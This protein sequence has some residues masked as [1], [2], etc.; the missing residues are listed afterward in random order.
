VQAAGSDRAAQRFLD[1]GLAER[2]A[3]RGPRRS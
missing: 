2:E 1:D 3:A